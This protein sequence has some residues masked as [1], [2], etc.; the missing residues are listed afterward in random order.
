MKEIIKENIRFVFNKLD[1][2]VESVLKKERIEEHLIDYYL[3]FGNELRER[4]GKAAGFTGLTEYLFFR[5]VLRKLETELKTNFL[6]VPEENSAGNKEEKT[7]SFYSEKLKVRLTH[8]IKIQGYF[9]TKQQPD[10]SIMRKREND[11]KQVNELVAV[12]EIKTVIPDKL[13]KFKESIEKLSGLT[14]IGNAPPYIF[15]ITFFPAPDF[16]ASIH[17]EKLEELK[18]LIELSKQKTF[19][20]MNEWKKEEGGIWERQIS[21]NEA[22]EKIVAEIRK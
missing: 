2:F 15:Y 13:S 22:I 10:I 7:K 19:I 16:Q 1:E 9:N 18:K 17:S 3:K 4:I 14:K 5:V 11:N 21:L 20:I 8:D 12:F 6:P